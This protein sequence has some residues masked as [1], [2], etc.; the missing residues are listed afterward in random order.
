MSFIG[1]CVIDGGLSLTIFLNES[2]FAPLV[3]VVYFSEGAYQ[4]MDTAVVVVEGAVGVGCGVVET[5]V[6]CGV[7]ETVE[8][9]V[10]LVDM[11]T[12]VG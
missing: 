9:G 11:A 10:V 8:T 3:C 5:S 6:G 7:V 1:F 4:D 12:G 2:V